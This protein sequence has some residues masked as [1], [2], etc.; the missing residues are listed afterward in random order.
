MRRGF[1]AGLS[2]VCG[3]AILLFVP[4]V[5]KGADGGSPQ[6]TI[7][8]AVPVHSGSIINVT[9]KNFRAGED[10]SN[11]GV[12]VRILPESGGQDSYRGYSLP[13]VAVR[14]DAK[15]SFRL[16][17]PLAMLQGVHGWMELGL[18]YQN[19][20][21]HS[22]RL[23]VADAGILPLYQPDAIDATAGT[24]TFGAFGHGG[25]GEDPAVNGDDVPLTGSGW[26]GELFQVDE[27]RYTT[28][29]GT[30]S[31]S[32]YNNITN[33]VTFTGGN[34]DATSSGV[35]GGISA[36]YK[37]VRV[38]VLVWD[39]P[40]YGTIV[41]TTTTGAV[42]GT[43]YLS[44]ADV[45]A[46]TMQSATATS[47][48]SIT[49]TFS[50]PVTT[51]ALNADAIDNWAVTFNGA[52]AVSALSPLGS[53]GTTTV[54]L[55]VA[56]LGDLGATP[57]VNFTTGA[58]EFEDAS[59]NDASTGSVLASDGISPATPTLTAPG[60]ATFMEGA[61]VAWSANA[62]A[63]TDGS[64]A[65]IRLQGSDNGSTWSDLG[66][67][68]TAPYSGTYNFGTKYTYYRAQ[69]YDN[70]SNTANSSATPNLQDA[71][72]LHL[73]TIPPST[74]ANVES[75]QWVVTVHDNYG[76]A[77]NVTQ[78]VALSSSSTSGQFRATSGGSQT[79]HINLNNASNGSFYYFDTRAG[80]FW[81]NVINVALLDD[82]TQYIVTANTTV[83]SI[84]IRT[85]S[86][87]GGSEVGALEIAGAGN[88]GSYN[89]TP[90]VYVAGYNSLGAY[91]QDV[92]ANWSVTGTLPSGGGSGF[93]NADPSSSNQYTAVSG[94]NCSGTIVATYS[95]LTDATGTVTVDATRPA[96]VTGF[97]IATD[98]NDS[99]YV[100]ATWNQTSSYDDGSN[101]AS[102]NV[103][104]FDVRYSAVKCS[105]EALWNA[106]TQVNQ[107]GKPSSFNGSNSWRI[108]MG[109]VFEGLYFYAIKTMDA[110]GNWSLIGSGCFTTSPDYSLP[111]TL[112]AFNANGGY[113]RITLSWST[114]SE[115]DVL[116]F[117]VWRDTEA[118]F[119]NPILVSSYLTNPELV[120][121]GDATT[122]AD[123]AFIDNQNLQ[124]GKTYY[125][126]LGTVDVNG[127]QEINPMTA[128][129]YCQALPSDFAL[130]PNFPNPF[131][132][133]T[134]FDLQLPI[135]STVSVTI[136]DLRG[137]EVA[138][139]VDN[140]NMEAG[141]YR[142]TWNGRTSQG[143]PLP[144]GLYFCRL[145]TPQTQRII[146]MMLLK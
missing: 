29:D 37:S 106:A 139:V 11:F 76:N 102:G 79:S 53:T 45:T 77:E 98:P 142:L 39:A 60:D 80:T 105:T 78:T 58:N 141:V 86:G 18:Y 21:L 131:N 55:T 93:A 41:Y 68:A 111:V 130:S 42:Q 12:V 89:V 14:T 97:N 61:S 115:V 145:Q 127:Q 122:G 140:Q 120:C 34:L 20:A 116:G 133:D 44:T 9:G 52:K 47:T 92:A 48:T 94:S 87:G 13:E 125:Y 62:G 88:G 54:T 22:N 51:P 109:D 32:V 135:N 28:L 121:H 24:L 143:T 19:R 3:L 38:T 59:G 101:P 57:T 134:Q 137:G 95:G 69:A 72:H 108:Y 129:A 15:G 104:N 82:S 112:S 81:I 26:S 138:R 40:N 64:L 56:D 110:Q 96:T 118:S 144:S 31:A 49:V 66:S 23:D 75:G 63:G 33:D 99:L 132:P 70:N 124:P 146:K 103:Y 6:I 5:A 136:Y 7:S 107:S 27:D 16:E 113:G 1:G 46:P 74:P 30:G 84:V 2:L 123:Y 43:G 100:N 71:H 36:T 73:T 85:A 117:Q 65:G 67:D 126:R 25:P 10:L 8:G 17:I 35:L 119:S 128:S 114:E 50:E 4:F 83:S 91:V 90:T